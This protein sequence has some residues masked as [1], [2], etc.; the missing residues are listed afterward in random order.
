MIQIEHLTKSFDGKVAVNDLS[1]QVTRGEILGFLGPNGAGKT[2]TVKILTGMLQPDGGA[3]RVAGFDVLHQPL[4]VK[5]RIGVVPESG[6]LYTS[7]SG[8][9]YLELIAAL[10]H[11]PR[12]LAERRAHELLQLF[13]I[14]AAR[15]QRMSGYS[16]GMKQ[17]V[18]LTA[19]LLP[20]PEV[21]FLDEP[22]NG[23]DA[24]AARVVKALLRKL[25][26]QGK[27]IFFCSHILEVVE[28]I[29]TR[30]VI[31][32]QGRQVIEGTTSSIIAR[33]GVQTLEEVF[34]QLTGV[35]DIGET[36]A[37]FLAALERV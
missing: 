5:K 28:R 12:D 14:A 16:K 29:C 15:D 7:L 33:T 31:I 6:A 3:A 9:E 17:K 10:H 25:A 4:E 2:T 21:L 27:T 22:L 23:L 26:D 1:L 11:L 20:N 37:E 30:I 36:T 24:N 19:A 18:L 35:Q 34:G 13:G 8:A 32:H